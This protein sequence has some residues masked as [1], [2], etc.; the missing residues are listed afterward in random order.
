MSQVTDLKMAINTTFGSILNEIQLSNLNFSIQ[1]TPFA[2]NIILKKSVQKDRNGVPASPSPPILYLLQQARQEHLAL[3][4]E[5]HKLKVA[6]DI[7]KNNYDTIMHENK[8]LRKEIEEKNDAIEVMEAD[9]GK[10]RSRLD[11]LE[12]EQAKNCVASAPSELRIKE[13]KNKHTMELRDLKAEVRKLTGALKVKEKVDKDL[14]NARETIKNLKSEKSLLKTVK[15]KLEGEARKLEKKIKL[16]ENKLSRIKGTESTEKNEDGTK[17]KP[18]DVNENYMALSAPD[19]RFPTSSCSL[20]SHWIP[21]FHTPPQPPH[22]FPSMISHCVTVQPPEEVKLLSKEDFLQ[23][24]AEHREQ[25]KK[26]WAEI[27]SKINILNI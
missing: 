6:S 13:M 5:N 24:W 25:M 22:S 18:V 20:V 19:L 8:C 15:T 23:L 21:Q 7:L 1:M 26:D 14:H 16:V 2:A 11:C 12:D 10:L 9:N 17:S 3:E 27:F 4:N